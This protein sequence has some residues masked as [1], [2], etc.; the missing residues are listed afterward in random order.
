MGSSA[1]G[2]AALAKS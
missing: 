1:M 2:A